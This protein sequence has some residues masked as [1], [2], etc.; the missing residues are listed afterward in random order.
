MSALDRDHEKV[1]AALIKDG[2]TITHDPLT[3]EYD[4][5]DL[6]IDLGAERLIAAERGTAKIAVEIKT[7]AG[8]SEVTSLHNAAGQYIV[9]Q[10]VLALVEP[11]RRL[12]L[13]VPG[14]VALTFFQEDLGELLIRNGTLRIVG[15]DPI[16]EKITIWLP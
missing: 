15:Y 8:P 14:D 16:E 2:W 6:H 3:I 13:A 5:R 10:S 4:R 9:Y 11:E 7:F 1:K 12:V